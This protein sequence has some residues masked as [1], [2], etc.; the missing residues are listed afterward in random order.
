M[1]KSHIYQNKTITYVEKRGEAWRSVEKRGEA[2]RSED[3]PGL[4]KTVIKTL[5]IK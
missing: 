1:Q 3:A 2:W 4:I 5:Q